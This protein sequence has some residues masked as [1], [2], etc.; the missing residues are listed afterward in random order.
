MA[1]R[2]RRV[3]ILLLLIVLIAVVSAF[4]LSRL[5]RKEASEGRLVLY[6]NVDIRQVDLAFKVTERV[7]QML[8]EEGQHVKKGQLLAT[9]EK[10][11]FTDAVLSKTGQVEAQAQ[12]LAR[13]QTGSRPEEI[14]RA[15]AEYDSAKVLADNAAVTNRRFQTLRELDAQ[16]AQRA[17]DANAA[18]LAAAAQA[19]AAKQTLDLAVEGP[20]AEDIAEAQATLANY[21]AQLQIAQRDL[22]DA[23]LYAPSDTVIQTRILEPGDIATPQTPAYILAITDPIWIRAYV[24]ETDLG[25]IH[26]GM[27]A[28]VTTDSFPGKV[29]DAWVGYISPTAEFTP[30]SVETTDIRTHLVY[31]IRVYVK[32]SENEL[33][34]GMPA[35]VVIDLP[36]APEEQQKP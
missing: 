35:T 32:N 36:P 11:R 25:K 5:L 24:S 22:A 10:S 14:A 29:Y 17:D 9:L 23:N 16:T 2:K 30:K 7:H 8:V 27:T 1:M 4:L 6:G 21:Q 13:L 15:R 34:L 26:E 12:V 3:I 33:R 19:L 31:Q 20:R 28:R 18:A